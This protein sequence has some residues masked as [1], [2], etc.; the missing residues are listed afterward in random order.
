LRAFAEPNDEKF[1][2]AVE[3]VDN[4]IV[5]T[6]RDF[7]EL[8]RNSGATLRLVA[9]ES[10]NSFSPQAVAMAAE[11]AGTTEVEEAEE[12]VEGELGGVLPDAHQFEFRAVGPRGTIRGKVDRALTPEELAV[13]N[14][15][16]VNVPARVQLQVRR[17]RRSGLIVRES[18]TLLKLEPRESAAT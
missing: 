7:F 5:S 11:R 18:F 10:D 16:F 1:Q 3:A 2:E 12:R 9:G 17:V 8:M 4:R 14:L 15:R 13:F 6:A